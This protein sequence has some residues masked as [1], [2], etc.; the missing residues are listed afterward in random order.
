MIK[1]V[2]IALALTT[3]LFSTPI[4]AQTATCL[5]ASTLKDVVARTEAAR[6]EKATVYEY[7]DG[8]VQA[9]REW[10]AKEFDVPLENV[11]EYDT[12][13]FVDFPSDKDN[14]FVAHFKDGCSVGSGTL[15]RPVFQRLLNF[16]TGA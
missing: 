1:K 13:V 9:I 12:D 14:V 2:L 16:L 15:P 8:D 5:S 10:I 6:N 4:M 7:K 3:T 11:V